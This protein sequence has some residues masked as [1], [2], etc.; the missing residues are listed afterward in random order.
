[1]KK[2]QFIEIVALLGEMS[3]YAE[4]MGLSD[5]PEEYSRNWDKQNDARQRIIKIMKSILEK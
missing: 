4:G 5:T 1:M 3:A 2:E